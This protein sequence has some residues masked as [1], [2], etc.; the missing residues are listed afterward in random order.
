MLPHTFDYALQDGNN[1]FLK[2]WLQTS[3]LEGTRY[4]LKP[5][6][7]RKRFLQN[8]Y[9]VHISHRSFVD[10]WSAYPLYADIF[11]LWVYDNF[12][13]PLEFYLNWKFHQFSVMYPRNILRMV[14]FSLVGSGHELLDSIRWKFHLFSVCRCNKTLFLTKFTLHTHID[15]HLLRFINTLHICS[16]YK[17]ENCH[18]R[19]LG[20]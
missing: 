6:S 10:L 9:T 19:S 20:E 2:R 15:K 16:L 17:H 13:L 18:C 11:A 7:H 12:A 8:S 1:E 14:A 5:K 4:A 3:D